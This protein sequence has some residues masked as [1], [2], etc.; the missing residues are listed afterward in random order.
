MVVPEKTNEKD[1]GQNDDNWWASVLADENYHSPDTDI[2]LPHQIKKDYTGLNWDK[3]QELYRQDVVISMQVVGHNRGG[4]LV[5][6]DDLKGFVPYSH[7][8]MLND[9]DDSARREKTLATYKEKKLQ[10]KVI[11]CT[12]EESRLVFSERAAQAGTGRRRELFSTLERGK[13]VTG[14]I[15]NITDFGVF[16]DLGGVEGLIHIS[17]LSWGRVGHPREFA[18]LKEKVQVQILDIS[19]ERSRV[20]LSIKRLHDNPWENAQEKYKIGQIVSAEIKALV[21]FGA[22]AR[23]D[24]GI[25]GLIH[26]SEIPPE[27]APLIGAQVDLRI[28]QIDAKK[29]RLALSLKI[30][31]D[32]E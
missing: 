19:L 17:E 30:I 12:P 26:S 15:T 32:Y 5:E 9:G 11:E 16:V 20:A 7:L 10:L 6:D 21:P 8:I 1:F 29:Q 22:F 14:E 4:V 25:E 18:Q 23:L 3:A 27:E 24:D 28:L 2:P 13:I 31:D